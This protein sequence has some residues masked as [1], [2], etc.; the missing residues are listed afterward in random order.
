[1]L[2]SCH[3]GGGTRGDIRF[4]AIESRFGA[5]YSD[6]SE[7]ELMTQETWMSRLDLSAAELK[8]QRTEGIAKGVAVGSAQAN[9]LAADASFG[10][11]GGRFFAG[12]F[13]YGVTRY[14]WQQPGNLPLQRVFVDLS[15]SARDVANSSGI[16]QAPVFAV[17]P[18]SDHDQK[19]L[20]FLT[21]QTPPA[22]AVVLGEENGEISFWLGG[23]S[24]QSLEAFEEGAV[25]AAIDAQGQELAQIEQTRRD[26][27]RGYGIVQGE[28]RFSFQ[29]ASRSLPHTGLLLR[30][31]VRGVP[32]DLSLRLGLDPS[33]EDDLDEMRSLLQQIRQVDPVPLDS[34]ETP[35]FLIGRMTRIAQAAAFEQGSRD[36]AA[37]ESIGLFTRGLIPIPQSF[38]QPNESIAAAA[39]RLVPR[40]Q[41]LLAGQILASVLNSDTSNLNLEVQVEVAQNNQTLARGG[42]RGSRDLVVQQREHNLNSLPSGSEV[43]IQV[44]N[45]EDRDLYVSLLAIGSSGRITVLYPNDWDAPEEAARLV[46]GQSLTAPEHE[47]HRNTQRDYCRNPS[48]EFHLCLTGRGYVEILTIASTRPLREALRVIARIAADTGIARRA[49]LSLGDEDSLDVVETLLGDI[50]RQSRGD[51]EVR[52]TRNAVNVNQMAALSTMIE[53]IDP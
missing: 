38:G 20:Y 50:D 6:P 33:L 48:E 52:T 18:G 37:L 34:G 8:Q 26:G 10:R 49:P 24:S 5:G 28:A 7:Q 53:I 51:I 44:T 21:P 31:R 43:L 45:H 1:M 29:D 35:H 16:Q 17:A 2:D 47:G 36:I 14:L 39:N 42:T 12:A 27:L 3:S 4:R 40:F 9:Q 25:F 23:V 11:G 13:T 32:P 22:E 41:L 19:P 46:S 30:E 15:R